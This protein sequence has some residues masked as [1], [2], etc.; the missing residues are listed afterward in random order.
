MTL[1]VDVIV[2]ALYRQGDNNLGV[3]LASLDGLPLP[4]WAPG[5]HINLHLRKNLIRQYSLTGKGDNPHQYEICIAREKI[6]RGGSAYVH[7][8]LRPGQIVTISEPKNLF[9]LVPAKKIILLAAGIG[10]TP[11]YAMAEALEA[12]GSSF[13]LHYY[14]KSRSSAAF[15]RELS[16][17]RLHGHC[18]FWYSSDGHSP[19]SHMPD[20]LLMPEKD[21]HIYMCGPEGFMTQ[22]TENALRQGWPLENIH[23]EAFRPPEASQTIDDNGAFTVTLA[24][25]GEQFRVPADKT[26]AVV[27]LENGVDVPLSCEMGMCGACLTPVV[28]GSVDHRDTVQ[29]DTEKSADQQQIALCCSRSH[30][31]ELVVAL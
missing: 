12:S 30:S 6:S 31:G 5:A 9:P 3:T 15:V 23:T 25:S 2:D 4:E 13:I 1:S 29:S 20:E 24:S 11:L 19:R 7:D 8:V 27:L 18:G 28:S 16:L 26:I 21:T 14:I 17:P 22:M 10:I